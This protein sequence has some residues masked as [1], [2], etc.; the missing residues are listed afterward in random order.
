MEGYDKGDRALIDQSIR[1]AKDALAIDPSSVQALLA[2]A[3]THANALFLQM[4]ADQEHA[5]REATWAIAR[6]IELDGTDAFGY[7]LRGFVVLLS[8]QSDRYPAA[9]ADAHHAHEMNP[10]DP[11]VLRF[12]AALEATLGEPERAD[13]AFASSPATEPAPVTQP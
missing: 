3:R 8:R 6:A 9:L 2:L 7:A 11:M 12:L 5:L 13:R 4:A 1:E 10:N